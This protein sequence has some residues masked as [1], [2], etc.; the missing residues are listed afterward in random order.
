M[1]YYFCTNPFMADRA[2]ITPKVLK[3]A[4]ETA[5]MSS[6]VAASKVN[7]SAEKLQEWEEGVSLP[8]IHQAENLARKF[9]KTIALCWALY[10]QQRPSRS[11]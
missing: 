7:V 8:T 10:H 2:Y 5:H 11:C 3:W 9:G 4:R 1:A 6:D